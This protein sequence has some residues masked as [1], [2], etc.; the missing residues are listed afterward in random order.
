MTKSGL[1]HSTILVRVSGRTGDT[2]RG[3]DGV[4]YANSHKL[5]VTRSEWQS[6]SRSQDLVAKGRFFYSRLAPE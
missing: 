3:Q 5:R 1:L 6:W 4:S 2:E